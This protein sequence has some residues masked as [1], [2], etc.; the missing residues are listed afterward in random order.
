M[1]FPLP[2]SLENLNRSRWMYY[3]HD[4]LPLDLLMRPKIGFSRRRASNSC[5]QPP[6]QPQT[7]SWGKTCTRRFA[8]R[9]LLLCFQVSSKGNRCY[10]TKSRWF[11]LWLMLDLAF[12]VVVS[13]SC[14]FFS[15]CYVFDC[16][17]TFPTNGFE[18]WRSDTT[19]LWRQARVYWRKR[20]SLPSNAPLP[21]R[22]A[23]IVRAGFVF[24]FG[25]RG[26]C[27]PV[28]WRQRY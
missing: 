23:S 26:Y 22:S 11:Q 2:P 7:Y 12:S 27:F 10:S 15:I 24:F 16:M 20:T 5:A 4:F 18:S 25:G 13:L 6:A 1:T 3:S 28:D 9:C 8:N 14:Q 17:M 21:Y 19:R